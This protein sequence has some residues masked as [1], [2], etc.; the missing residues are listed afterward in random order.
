MKI[1]AGLAIKNEE[2][3]IAKTLDALSIF[4]D[5]IVITDDNSSDNMSFLSKSRIS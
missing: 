3:I 2:W 4:C 1:V 5:K